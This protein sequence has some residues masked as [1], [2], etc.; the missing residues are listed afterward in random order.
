[1]EKEVEKSV[2]KQGK[3]MQKSPEKI[4]QTGVDTTRVTL[5]GNLQPGL[6]WPVDSRTVRSQEASEII[7]VD[8][9]A[10]IGKGDEPGVCGT[11][12][13]EFWRRRTYLH[14]ML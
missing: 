9:K 11:D 12:S 7:V 3:R 10:Q 14:S 13:P 2:K 5:C 8:G 4:Q 6:V 1:V